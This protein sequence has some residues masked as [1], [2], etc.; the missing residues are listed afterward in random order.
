MICKARWVIQNK[1]NEQIKITAKQGPWFLTTAYLWLSFQKRRLGER[2]LH[3]HV[4]SSTW[5]WKLSQFWMSL[6]WK[7]FQLLHVQFIYLDL[8]RY[9]LLVNNVSDSKQKGRYCMNTVF[10]YRSKDI[11]T[12]SFNQGF[13]CIHHLWNF[14]WQNLTHPSARLLFLA[15][16]PGGACRSI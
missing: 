10:Y 9:C 16:R 5:P 8:S 3:S 6:L 1:T 4:K 14:I 13:C 11:N 2:R 7:E 15:W 12:T